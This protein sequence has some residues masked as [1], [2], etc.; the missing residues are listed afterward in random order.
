[1]DTIRNEIAKPT[2]PCKPN[3][4]E[5]APDCGTNRASGR[6]TSDKT[7][8]TSTSL[9]VSYPEIALSKCFLPTFSQVFLT[10]CGGSCQQPLSPT[11][12]PIS[13]SFRNCEFPL[14]PHVSHSKV[15]RG[16]LRRVVFSE[17]QRKALEKTFQKQ[18]YI[19]KTDRKKLATH[20]G[21]KDSQVKIWFQN[22]R[23]KWRNTKERELLTQGCSLEQTLQEK[24]ASTSDLNITPNSPDRK[25]THVVQASVCKYAAIS[26]RS[27]HSHTAENSMPGLKIE[28]L[29]AIQHSNPVQHKQD[30]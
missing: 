11:A 7:P 28:L 15:R 19:S 2:D 4:S 17:E 3:S 21:L 16:I 23:M 22:R 9:T 26:S 30:T 24:P 6:S 20:L 14:W 5:S 18:K 27:Q 29:E 1:M 25:A 13:G 12:F 10:C 8:V